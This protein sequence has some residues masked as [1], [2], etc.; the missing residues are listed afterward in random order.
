VTKVT[1]QDILDGWAQ[2]GTGEPLVP[3]F[4]AA[5]AEELNKPMAKIQL[6]I[7]SYDADLVNETIG[8]QVKM[9]WGKRE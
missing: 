3:G 4:A 1:E 7:K 6:P 9:L 5:L 8:F 2:W